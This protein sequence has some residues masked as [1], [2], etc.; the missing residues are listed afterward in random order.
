MDII[1]IVLNWE[2]YADTSRL[3]EGFDRFE[4]DIDIRV[5]DN[6]STDDSVKRLESDGRN[7][8]TLES[9]RG[10]A[11]GMNA[12]IRVALE[13]GADAVLL[14]NNDII[15]DEPFISDLSACLTQSDSIGAVTP[16]IN[17][18]DGSSW[19]R[20]ASADLQTGK[21]Y[22]CES[23]S[24]N[25]NCLKT[26]YIPLACTLID[27]SV[28]DDIGLLDDSYF[29]YKEDVDF[30]VRAAEY[31]YQFVTDVSITVKHESG[32]SS[33]EATK[34][35]YGIR[36]RLIFANKFG[37]PRLKFYTFF[38]YRFVESLV[39]CIVKQE[40]SAFIAV[41]EGVLDGLRGQT[42]KG[43]YP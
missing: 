34:R 17:S 29:L 40:Y 7:V 30:A 28:F 36:N 4:S 5:V 23:T 21:S 13:D 43:R 37:L 38:A 31:G 20:T 33:D 6:G 39:G 18:P 19:F 10:F 3:L 32:S 12:G 1:G 15:I 35:Y 27:T 26:Y 16:A 22:R 41:L 25:G 24:L 14:L 2:N 9:N 8:I 11:G 42:G